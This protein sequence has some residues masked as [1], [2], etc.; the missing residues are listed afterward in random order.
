MAIRL[1]KDINILNNHGD[2]IHKYRRRKKCL[3]N[4]KNSNGRI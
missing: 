3:K 4:D 2:N 1:L